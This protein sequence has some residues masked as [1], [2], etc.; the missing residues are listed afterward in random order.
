MVEL[1]DLRAVFVLGAPVLLLLWA[2]VRNVVV[3][4]PNSNILNWLHGSSASG[5]YAEAI[6]GKSVVGQLKI[7]QLWIRLPTEGCS[8]GHWQPT[9]FSA[10]P[11]AEIAEERHEVAQ[12]GSPEKT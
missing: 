9:L 5:T 6:S 4:A 12:A 10:Q 7:T 11:A 3:V 2:V 1:L 8:V